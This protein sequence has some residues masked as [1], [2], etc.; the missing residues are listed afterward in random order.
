[1]AT[2]SSTITLPPVVKRFLRY[3]EIDTQSNPDSET[4][5]STEKQKNL[6]ELL[7]RELIEI[8]FYDASMDENG[9]VFATLPGTM[10]AEEKNDSIVVALLAHM[11]TAPD[12]SG[13]NVKPVVH[14]PYE[15]N[16]ISLPGDSS[17]KL[18]PNRQ[19][20]LIRH[21][22]ERLITSDGTTL[23]GSDDKAGIAIL[24]QY[25]EDMLNDSS[26][27]PDV[28]ICFT[29]DE[30]IGRGVDHLNLQDLGAD[31]AYTLDGSGVDT[32]S[33][34]TFNAAAAT[35]TVTGRS[36]HP[37]YAK[38]VMVNA[39]RILANLIASLPVDEAPETTENR[40]GYFHPHT[41]SAGDVT[42]ASVQIILRDFSR[43]GLD[44]RKGLVQSL[45]ATEREKN[46]DARISL[47][48]KDQYKN[49]RS[50]IETTD[51]RAVTFA[52]AAASEMGF[53]LKEEIVRGGTDGARLSEMGLPTPNIFN[54]GYDYH[55]RFEWNTVENLERSLKYTKAL[56]RY[57]GVHMAESST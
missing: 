27:R 42:S 33:F 30:E 38:G 31:I 11:D 24:M 43:T 34:E 37:G 48:I 3:V 1:M 15:G 20:N 16:V 54:G 49:M 17:I 46:P 53:E 4:V 39:V 32:I 40:Q 5:P 8:G 10:N 7:V 41:M 12:E 36:V 55:S 45:V 13:E 44:E 25:A 47:K 18:D 26:P 21:K 23:L 9:Y 35:I 50:Y 2:T 56:V 28:R 19:P 29:I 51:I 22:G 14:L 6:G 52:C 57:W